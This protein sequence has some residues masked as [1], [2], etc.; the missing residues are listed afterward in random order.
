MTSV[1]YCVTAISRLTGD[2]E[3]ISL[4]SSKEQAEKSCST[5]KKIPSRKRVYTYP[6]VEVA[7]KDL[8]EE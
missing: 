2:R 5:F 8:F 3:P 1:L 6:K 7:Q 4:P